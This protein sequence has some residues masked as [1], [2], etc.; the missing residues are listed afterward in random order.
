MDAQNAAQSDQTR[1][2]G[3]EPRRPD[4]KPETTKSTPPPVSPRPSEPVDKDKEPR[5]PA[6]SSS[7]PDA[8]ASEDRDSDAE[9]IVL[10]GKDGHSPS[11][12]RK[13]RQEDKS[14]GDA[15]G[16][17]SKSTIQAAGCP[18]HDLEKH[19]SSIIARGDPIK[20]KRLSAHLEREKQS[21]GKD[22]ASSGLSSAPAS[23]PQHRRQ[24]RRRSDDPHSSSDSEH[25]RPR[26][27]KTSLREKLK[28]CRAPGA[29]Q[30]K[31]L[32]AR[33]R[34]RGRQPQG[35]TPANN[36]RRHRLGPPAQGAQG[37]LWQVT[38]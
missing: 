35:P 38:P 11:K 21:R 14:D 9:T 26:P 5:Q 22:A 3:D 27:S 1:P 20:K 31:G 34:R 7:A 33:I 32:K 8:N 2:A 4:P 17:A 12:A 6:N 30:T 25:S 19:Q 23:P 18:P 16:D 29:T 10:P 24:H 37:S 15:D 36:Q 13:V 28:I